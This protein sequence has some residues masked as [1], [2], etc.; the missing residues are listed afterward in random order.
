MST[1]QQGYTKA[2]RLDSSPWVTPRTLYEARIAFD[3]IAVTEGMMKK[4][5]DRTKEQP[6]ITFYV[7]YTIKGVQTIKKFNK[8]K[9]GYWKEKYLEYK[10]DLDQKIAIPNLYMIS[11]VFTLP[12]MTER[13]WYKLS[14]TPETL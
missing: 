3:L 6:S 2:S 9:H 10:R 4:Y 14:D 13:K 12:D 1:T 5:E 8:P 7:R 11:D